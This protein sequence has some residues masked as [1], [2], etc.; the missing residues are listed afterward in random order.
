MVLFGKYTKYRQ[1]FTFLV[2]IFLMSRHLMF[3]SLSRLLSV[4]VSVSCMPD[5]TN[6]VVF[7]SAMSCVKY[8]VLRALRC[9]VTAL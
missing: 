1:L 9:C 4:V 6:F 7:S 8:G 5:S 3:E 2:F